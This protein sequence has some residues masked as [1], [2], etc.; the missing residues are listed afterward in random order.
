MASITGHMAWEFLRGRYVDR[1]ETALGRAL[2]AEERAA[3]ADDAHAGWW[4]TSLMLLLR[5]D[6]VDERYRDLPPA[7]YSLPSRLRPDFPNR[8]GG[9]GYVGHPARG[10]VDF[11]RAVQGVL[12]DEAL[13]LVAQLL[14]RGRP[15]RQPRSPFFFIPFLR[16]NFWPVAAGTAEA[17]LALAGARGPARPESSPEPPRK[18]AAP[19]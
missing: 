7:R 3:F 15:A 17:A 13:V 2:S 8:N 19:S 5:P 14:D 1:I 9:Q 10:D 11:A 16:T 4:E 6:L 18:G 12:L